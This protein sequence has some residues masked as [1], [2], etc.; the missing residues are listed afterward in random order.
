MCR[1]SVTLF[2][3]IWLRPTLL[4]LDLLIA[5]RRSG[6][7]VVE[8]QETRTTARDLPEEVW[9]PIKQKTIDE[10]IHQE[11]ED[12]FELYRCPNCKFAL[13]KN[14]ETAL[15]NDPSFAFNREKKL[16]EAWSEWN[17]PKCDECTTWIW[18]WF[19]DF[20][21]RRPNAAVEASA[22]T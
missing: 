3:G 7:L 17:H 8:E 21:W 9:E 11:G 19:G 1:S 5:R 16:E 2:Y 6:K 20:E 18:S 4:A 13:G 14:W 10:A 22:S 15:A 12:A